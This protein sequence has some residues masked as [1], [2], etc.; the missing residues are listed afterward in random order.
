MKKDDM[1]FLEN[2][3][4]EMISLTTDLNIYSSCGDISN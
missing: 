4:E 1:Q 3:A 2:K